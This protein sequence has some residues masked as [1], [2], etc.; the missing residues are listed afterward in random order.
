METKGRN[1]AKYKIQLRKNIQSWK[2]FRHVFNSFYIFFVSVKQIDGIFLLHHSTK[3]ID[4]IKGR[5]K[6]LNK[7]KFSSDS[8][9][10]E[11]TIN[12]FSSILYYN[13]FLS[14]SS[15][16]LSAEQAN[17]SHERDMEKKR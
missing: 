3:M 12:I 8:V 7:R 17:V 5:R 4:V 11:Q 10:R 9:H 6:H 2:I 14:S 15:N 1:V 13:N 16:F